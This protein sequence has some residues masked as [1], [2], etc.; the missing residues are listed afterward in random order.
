[1]NNTDLIHLPQTETPGDLHK[2]ADRIN[3]AHRAC[4]SSLQAGL[5]HALAAG[6]PLQP[7]AVPCGVA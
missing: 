5:R 2:L 4:E 1:M 3:Q 7:S 6:P